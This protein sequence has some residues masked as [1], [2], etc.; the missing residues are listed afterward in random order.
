MYKKSFYNLEIENFEDKKTLIY[1]SLTSSVGLMDSNGRKLYDNI[2]NI[3]IENID[4]DNDKNIFKIL[5]DNGYIIEKDIDELTL[6]KTAGRI[7]RYNNSYFGLTIAPTLDCNMACPYCFEEHPKLYMTKEVADN[8][9]KFIEERIDK[10]KTKHLDIAWYGGEPLLNLDILK[11]LSGKI[12]DLCEKENIEYSAFIITNGV[13]L[14]KEVA[15]VLKDC[16]ITGAQV[17]VDG[18][19]EINDTRRL[20]LNGASSFDIISKN[21]SVAK[22]YLHINVR[23][24]IDKSNVDSIEYLQTYFK[25]LGV[26]MYVAPVTKINEVCNLIGDECFTPYEFK[27]IEMQ[28]LRDKVSHHN[29]IIDSIVP[30][31]KPLGCGALSNNAFVIDPEGNLSKCWNHIGNKSKTVGNVETG[32]LFNSVNNKWLTFEIDEKCEKCKFLPACGGG[33][34]DVTLET[35]EAKCNHARFNS[36]E[37]IKILYDK[38]I[39]YKKNDLIS[40]TKMLEEQYE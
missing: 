17:T 33:C 3:N 30:H 23:C 9:V 19:K 5:V 36:S 25:D 7:M 28:V 1:N 31:T 40:Q 29:S 16:K 32:E 27:D 13:L 4:N 24:N 15:K 26:N 8:V 20:L 39:E 14:T 35:G 18:P 22:D 12:I 21:L 11:Y 10:V 34:P 37:K 6:Y 2:E 38:Y